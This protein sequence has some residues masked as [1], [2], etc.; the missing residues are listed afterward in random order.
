[1]M[2]KFI[3]EVYPYVIIVIVVVLIRSFVVTPVIVNG[4]SMEKTLYEGELLI[5][6]K[7]DKEFNKIDRFD[8]VV[9]ND[10]KDKELIIKRI[11]GMPG[12]KVEYIDNKLYINDELVKDVYR[13][14]KTKN[15]RIKDICMTDEKYNGNCE[16]DVVPD[17]TYLVLGDNREVSLDSRVLGFINSDDIKGTTRLRLW[18]L[19][20]IGMVK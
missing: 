13:N 4:P 2:N 17:D 1:M 11:I 12:D 9:I 20:K 8:I 10:K 15:F 7:I 5:L 14:G 3:K 18:P 6:N 16:F 19:N